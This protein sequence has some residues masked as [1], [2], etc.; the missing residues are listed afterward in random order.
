MCRSTYY[1]LIREKRPIYKP[2]FCVFCNLNTNL[3]IL[4]VVHKSLI[5]KILFQISQGQFLVKQIIR[6]KMYIQ[7]ITAY[8]NSQ[9]DTPMNAHST[10][11]LKIVST[12]SD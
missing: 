9:K 8:R 12:S 1:I 3:Y 7:I 5:L 10:Q 2:I 11:N 6:L 4:I